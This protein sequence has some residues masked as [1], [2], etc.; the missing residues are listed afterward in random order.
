MNPVVEEWIQIAKA[1]YEEAAQTVHYCG[2]ILSAVEKL[3][4]N[5]I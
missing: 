3:I 5:N 2:K 4:S 1:D